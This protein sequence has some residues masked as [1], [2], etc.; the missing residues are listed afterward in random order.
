MLAN[1]ALAKVFLD[2]RIR[3]EV[4]GHFKMLKWFL[5]AKLLSQE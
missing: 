5:W 4:I 3:K 1:L 2:K